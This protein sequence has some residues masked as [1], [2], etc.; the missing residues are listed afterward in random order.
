M[1][2]EAAEGVVQL[3][4]RADIYSLGVLAYR[5]LVGRLPFPFE[6]DVHATLEAHIN[7]PVPPP[8]DVGAILPVALESAFLRALEKDPVNRQSSAADFWIELAGAADDS[9][10]QWRGR[11]DLETVIDRDNPSS[12]R[13]SEVHEHQDGPADITSV[14][15]NVQATGNP[16][17]K[18]PSARIAMPVFTPKRRHRWSGFAV[19]AIVGVVIAFAVVI[20]TNVVTSAAPLAIESVTVTVNA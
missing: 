5:L 2:P 7:E 17:S 14:G 8:A 4:A 18:L 10:P 19:S 15:T 12:S 13:A 3:T 1:S 20:L 11:V 16:G 6:G 9:W